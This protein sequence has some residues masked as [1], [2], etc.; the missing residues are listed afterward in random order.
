MPSVAVRKGWLPREGFT[1]DVV[2]DL[3]QKTVLNPAFTLPLLLLARYARKGEYAVTHALALKRLKI[4][5]YLGLARWVNG[6]L[7]RGALNNWTSDSWDWEKELVVITGGSDGI[8]KVLVQLFATLNAR[9][10][11]LDI[12]EP[13]FDLPNPRVHYLP[14]DVSSPSA[15]AS[16]ASTIRS[17]HGAPTI[18]ILN[19][20]IANRRPILSIPDPLLTR[21]F[22]INTLS[23]YRLMREF[24]PA[25]AAA[26]HGAIVT[27]ASLAGYITAPG[28]VDYASTKASAIA[29][30]EGV[31]AELKY[32]Y[33]APK[34]R[35]VCVCPTFTRT[36][37]CEGFKGGDFMS[38]YL[39]VETVGEAVFERVIRGQSGFVVLPRTAEWL[40]MTLRSWPWWMQG[41]LVGR[42]RD[43]MRGAEESEK[44]K[45][46]EAER[47]RLVAE[48]EEPELVKEGGSEESRLATEHVGQ[49]AK[50]SE[51]AEAVVGEEGGEKVE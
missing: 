37:L 33:E 29:F 34:V 2:Q 26:N 8:G 48:K 16:T 43:V 45:D 15:I 9:I 11:I 27:V 32:R 28:L 36:K 24:L 6:F 10:L 42:S 30:H 40:V 22:A 47:A 13:T 1:A 35:T 50:D 41:L 44:E 4:C 46:R 31:A 49:E 14:L 25:I 5:L 38:P 23:H 18:V 21:L 12:Q 3:I 19:A 39:E 51:E 17:R 20:G 7:S